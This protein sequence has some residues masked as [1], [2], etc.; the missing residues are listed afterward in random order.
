MQRKEEKKAQAQVRLK[1]RNKLRLEIA[2]QAIPVADG[3]ED[4]ELSNAVVEDINVEAANNTSQHALP[5]FQVGEII[6]VEGDTTERGYTYIFIFFLRRVFLLSTMTVKCRYKSTGGLGTVK[7]YVG[8]IEEEH[9]YMVSMIPHER[10]KNR[11]L[12]E[13]SISKCVTGYSSF[14]EVLKADDRRKRRRQGK[15]KESTYR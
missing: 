14:E 8:Y 10:G 9:W 11:K 15:N 13:R 5:A 1:E 6:S 2:R 4:E 7:E 3:D 12:Q